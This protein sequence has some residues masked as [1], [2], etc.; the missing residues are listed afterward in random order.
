MYLCNRVVLLKERNF[1]PGSTFFS[2]K[3]EPIFEEAQ[4]A[5]NQKLTKVASLV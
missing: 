1:A 5:G 3:M 4:C 2:I